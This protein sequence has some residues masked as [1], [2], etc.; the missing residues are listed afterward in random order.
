MIGDKNYLFWA[1]EDPLGITFRLT[2][3]RAPS[4]ILAQVSLHPSKSW[5]SRLDFRA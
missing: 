5:D 2:L 3:G 1:F 4:L